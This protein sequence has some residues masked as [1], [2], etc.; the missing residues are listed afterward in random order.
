MPTSEEYENPPV[1]TEFAGCIISRLSEDFS[2]PTCDAK[3]I[4]SVTPRTGA[5]LAELPTKQRRA[6]E[7][8]A[9]RVQN[10]LFPLQDELDRVS[11]DCPHELAEAGLTGDFLVAAEVEH[12][13]RGDFLYIQ[14]CECQELKVP[15]DNGPF[16]LKSR[17]INVLDPWDS[18]EEIT[19]T[20]IENSGLNLSAD[21]LNQLM[22]WY[23]PLRAVLLAT[24][25]TK[26]C[27]RDYC[28]GQSDFAREAL[29]SED[30]DWPT[31]QTGQAPS[32]D[33]LETRRRELA[34]EREED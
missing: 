9:R 15:L 14:I 4:K 11:L 20:E 23:Q 6:I 3:I 34:I 16:T 25:A 32:K 28:S 31:F 30:A 24:L 22:V 1:H 27:D 26:R 17:V 8:F 12:Q 18:S 19:H 21:S 29:H 10:A 7:V 2:C 33:W 5:C 13:E